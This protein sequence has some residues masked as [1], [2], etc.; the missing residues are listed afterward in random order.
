MKQARVRASSSNDTRDTP[1]MTTRV[2]VTRTAIR[3]AASAERGCCKNNKQASIPAT[4]S[5]AKYRPSVKKADAVVMMPITHVA[6]RKKLTSR[7]LM[8]AQLTSHDTVQTR[9]SVADAAVAD[10]RIE[11]LCPR[12]AGTG[13]FVRHKR[14]TT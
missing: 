8:A 5:A 13:A 11:T 4:T 1:V 2:G 7:L 9:S 3:A 6:I 12:V 14:G 10:T